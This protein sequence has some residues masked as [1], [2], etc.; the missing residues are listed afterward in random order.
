M[1]AV[2][3]AGQIEIVVLHIERITE[4]IIKRQIYQ[5]INTI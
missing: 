5:P 4:L 1:F 2:I 3:P